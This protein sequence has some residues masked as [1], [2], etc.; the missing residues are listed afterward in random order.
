VS[1]LDAGSR[2][3]APTAPPPGA[4]QSD[5]ISHIDMEDYHIDTVISHI[6]SPY[7][8]SIS[9][10]TISIYRVSN[11]YPISHIGVPLTSDLPYRSPISMSY[12]YRIISCHSGA[13]LVRLCIV[14]VGVFVMGGILPMVAPAPMPPSEGA[15]GQIFTVP[16]VPR[17]AVLPRP[18][19]RQ[20]NLQMLVL[21]GE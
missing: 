18:P 2:A 11:R 21:S 14:Y 19:Q 20:V 1:H 12:R 10:M 13:R 17:A 8:I 6:I 15:S 5:K 3:S 7:P 4:R 16:P 9:R